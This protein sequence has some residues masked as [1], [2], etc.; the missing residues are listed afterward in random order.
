MPQDSHNKGQYMV[1]LL[2]VTC[3]WAVAYASQWRRFLFAVFRNHSWSASAVILC[4]QSVLKFDIELFWL[5]SCTASFSPTD[6]LINSWTHVNPWHTGTT[7]YVLQDKYPLLL[8][9]CLSIVLFGWRLFVLLPIHFLHDTN[10]FKEHPHILFSHFF[11]KL[12]TLSQKLFHTLD[13]LWCSSLW[14]INFH[15]AL[16]EMGEQKLLTLSRI[17]E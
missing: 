17:G 3:K 4:G 16:F 12:L 14:L 10:D 11:S 9:S 7:I 8:W 15:Y 5:L 2:Y 6:C 1:L 13:C